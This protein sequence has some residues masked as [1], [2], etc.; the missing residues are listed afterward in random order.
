MSTITMSDAAREAY[1]AYQ[2]EWHRKNKDKAKEY[3][4]K[5]WEKKAQQIAAERE[6]AQS[7]TENK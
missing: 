6:A 5:A 4:A 3:R 2:R 7:E 1:N